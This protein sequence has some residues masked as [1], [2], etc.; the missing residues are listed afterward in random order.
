MSPGKVILSTGLQGGGKTILAGQFASTLALAG[1]KVFFLSTE[2][3][4]LDLLRRMLADCCN[5][6]FKTMSR[7][8]KTIKLKDGLTIPDPIEYG[9]IALNARRLQTCLAK[10]LAFLRKHDLGFEPFKTLE[11]YLDDLASQGRPTDVLICDYLREPLLPVNELDSWRLREAVRDAARA[12]REIATERNILVIMFCQADPTLKLNKK[13]HPGDIRDWPE[14][15]HFAD[16]FVGISHRLRDED[17]TKTDGKIYHEVQHFTVLLKDTWTETVI[18]VMTNF[19]FQRFESYV[20]LTSDDA[21]V[22]ADDSKSGL[23]HEIEVQSEFPGYVLLRREILKKLFTLPNLN[24]V[25]VYV[26]LMLTAGYS[27]SNVGKSW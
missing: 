1:H 17:D 18:P 2:V 20:K 16:A 6:E 21:V 3:R 24:S 22:S 9:E 15:Y 13:M 19:K 11:Q 8:Y 4:E 14:L 10:N 23:A 27:G 7:G 26:F 12:L 25:N 5:W